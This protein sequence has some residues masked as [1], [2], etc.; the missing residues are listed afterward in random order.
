MS[1]TIL[2]VDDDVR[3]LQM[4][5][6]NLIQEGFQ[7]LTAKNGREAIITLRHENPDLIILDLMMP[8]MDGYT[9]MHQHPASPT[10]PIIMLT[11]KVEEMEKILGLELGADDYMTKPFSVRELIAR[12][13]AQLRR[14]EKITSKQHLARPILHVAHLTL[15]RE[16]RIVTVNG[17]RIELTRSEFTILEKFM[18]APKRVYSRRE[19]IIDIQGNAIDGFERS[20]DVHIR[21]LRLKIEPDP[22]RPQYIESVYGVGYRFMGGAV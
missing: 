4:L 14:V 7:V 8:H 11:A 9:F 19:L 5:K 3:M 16:S 10:R 22:G 2:I 17:E 1:K 21:N 13:R 12:V 20:I 18:Q 6:I 15:D